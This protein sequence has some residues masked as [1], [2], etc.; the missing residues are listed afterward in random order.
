VHTA[1]TRKGLDKQGQETVTS[2]K[3]TLASISEHKAQTDV[4]I[5]NLRQ[6]IDQSQDQVDS[7]LNTTLNEV[8]SNVQVWES[9]VQSVKQANNSE[10]MRLNKAIS[11]LEAKITAGVA[12]SN[13]TTIQQATGTRATTVGQM[14]STEGTVKSDSIGMIVSFTNEVNAYSMSAGSGSANICITSVHVRG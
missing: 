7:K 12:D 5:A 9:Q 14:Y 3:T 4:N 11:I 2:S 1:Q 13:M 8:R 10:I 6:E